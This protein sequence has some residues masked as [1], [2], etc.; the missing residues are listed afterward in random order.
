MFGFLDVKYVD[1]RIVKSL[2]GGIYVVVATSEAIP[3]TFYLLGIGMHP[4]RVNKYRGN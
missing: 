4:F 1:E 3:G 2:H